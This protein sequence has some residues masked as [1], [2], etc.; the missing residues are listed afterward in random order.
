MYVANTAILKLQIFSGRSHFRLWVF[1]STSEYFY[2]WYCW[3]LPQVLQ[4]KWCQDLQKPCSIILCFAFT[5]NPVFETALKIKP[6]N[7]TS[8]ERSPRKLIK[9][10]SAD[11]EL[12]NY[13]KP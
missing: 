5:A 11:M 13:Q 8:Q 7:I 9:R 1:A 6:V 12:S 10:A 4:G 2:Y 3:V